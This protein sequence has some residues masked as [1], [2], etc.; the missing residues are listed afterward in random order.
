LERLTAREREV[1]A[2]ITEELSNQTIC[3][4]LWLSAGSV[5][6]HI[7]SIFAKPDLPMDTNSHRRVLALLAWLQ[8][9]A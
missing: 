4:T 7:S 6:K 1:L 2:P 5:E 9:G 3:E 8:D